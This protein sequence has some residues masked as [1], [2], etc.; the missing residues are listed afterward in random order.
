[1]LRD[2]RVVAAALID[3]DSGMALDAW[4]RGGAQ[5]DQPAGSA[6][7]VAAEGWTADL[8]FCAAGHAELL[9]VARTLPGHSDGEPA[10]DELVVS[11]GPARH[12]LLRAIP[13][14]HGD[15]LVLSIVVDGSRRF[16]ER[17]RRRLR[18]VALDALTAGPTVVRRPGT[19]G[20]RTSGPFR[21]D[22]HSD[23]RGARRPIRPRPAAPVEP[24]GPAAA[25][26]LASTRDGQRQ[27]RNAAPPVRPTSGTASAAAGPSPRGPLLG[28]RSGSR[29]GP[30]GAV[31]AGA[32]QVGIGVAPASAPRP[33]APPSALPPG[34]RD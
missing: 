4:T 6:T 26:E 21:S 14:P 29:H 28:R 19:G 32:E 11:A 5:G 17:V 15:R 10:G 33:P 13:D 24:A 9:R 27:G 31:Q 2:P 18:A 25:R 23:G 1:M 8:E 3:V 16:A 34:R 30:V 22:H 12:H 20:W 7:T